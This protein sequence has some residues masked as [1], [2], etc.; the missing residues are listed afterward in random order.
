MKKWGF[1][2]ATFSDMQIGRG[3]GSLERTFFLTIFWAKNDCAPKHFPP[4]RLC[5]EVYLKPDH[6]RVVNGHVLIQNKE[7]LRSLYV[8][9]AKHLI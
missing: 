4:A 3:G 6:L 7:V 8:C 9:M 2:S 1:I 5:L